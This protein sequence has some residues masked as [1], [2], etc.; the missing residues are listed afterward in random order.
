MGAEPGPGATRSPAVGADSGANSGDSGGYIDIASQNTRN[1]P[2]TCED[3]LHSLICPCLCPVPV[4]APV[5]ALTCPVCRALCCPALTCPVCR[6][7]SILEEA[8]SLHGQLAPESVQPLHRRLRQ[9]LRQLR[10]AD[11]PAPGRFSR[12]NSQRRSV[13]SKASILRYG[14]RGLRVWTPQVR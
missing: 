3:M 4:I 6:Q 13:D 1:D 12:Q 7:L 14:R 11:S 2:N 10:Q 8:L 9:C 5:P